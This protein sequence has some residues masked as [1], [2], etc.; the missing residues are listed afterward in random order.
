MTG[1]YA[2]APSPLLPFAGRR[3]GVGHPPGG[4]AD[5]LAALGSHIPLPS[6]RRPVLQARV[7]LHPLRVCA[8]P[9]LR[10]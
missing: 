1:V 4:A 8:D 6:R 7:L 2:R 9:S 5:P 10:R 3:A